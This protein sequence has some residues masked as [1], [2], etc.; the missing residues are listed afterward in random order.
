MSLT[1]KSTKSKQS[2]N[3]QRIN[4]SDLIVGKILQMS[5]HK[6]YFSPMISS[7]TKRKEGGKHAARVE[8]KMTN[9][10]TKALRPYMRVQGPGTNE[11][12]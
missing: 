7:N 12:C 6:C 2:T 5:N 11:F 1:S 10:E 9:H 3:V 4:F 8:S